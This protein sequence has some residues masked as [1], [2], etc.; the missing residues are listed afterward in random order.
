MKIINFSIHRI[1]LISVAAILFLS[2]TF[3]LLYIYNAAQQKITCRADMTIKN[4]YSTFTGILD[5]KIGKGEGIANITGSVSRGFG[6]EYLVQRT[7]FLTLTSYGSNPVWISNKIVVSDVENAPTE[8]LSETLPDFYL[9]PS[10][11]TDVN[12]IP[13]SKNGWL[14]TKSSIPLLYCQNYKVSH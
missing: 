5:F 10:T 2:L 9:K 7:V 13:V 6:T 4:T 1:A 8:L 14:I 12:I 11:T 3:Y